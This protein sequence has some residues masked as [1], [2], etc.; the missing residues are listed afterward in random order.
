[1]NRLIKNVSITL[2]ILALISGFSSAQ[3]QEKKKLTKEMCVT[4]NELPASLGFTEVDAKAINYLILQ[5]LKNHEVKA[6]GFVVGS[7]IGEE[8]DILGEWLNDGH[9]L[10][11]MTNNNQDYHQVDVES[12]LADI[13]SGEEAV[14]PMLTGFGQKNKY[15]R[16]PYLHYGTRIEE[17]DAAL[18]FLDEHNLIVAHATIVVDDYLFNLSLEKMG[19]EPDSMILEQLRDEYMEHV[20]DAIDDAEY[21]SKEL[22]KKNCRQILMLRANRLNA[23]FLEDILNL[24]QYYEYK[25]VSLERA[26]KDPLYTRAEAYFDTRGVGYLDMI[27]QSDPDLLP[28]E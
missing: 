13:A 20:A 25:F 2:A 12:F 28:A 21:K 4:F 5:A 9:T 8:F 6:A 19:K 23:I 7:Y 22:L 15:F 27:L 16:F 11:S 10:G 14:E 17:K 18:N 24:I 26:L 1:M 3:T